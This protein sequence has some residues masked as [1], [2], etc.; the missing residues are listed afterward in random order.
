M[1][2]TIFSTHT[3]LGA[4]YDDEV[5]QP[6]SNYWLN[7]CFPGQITFDTEYVDFSKL[8]DQRK[9]APLVVPTTQGRPMYSAAEQ[10]VQVKPAYVKPKDAVS[11]TRV[12]KKAAGF[13][14]LNYQSN[15]SAA[16]RYNMLVADILNTHRRGIER[17]W[18]WLASE[19]VQHGKVTL[20]GDAYPETVI[21]FER[22]PGH[23]KSLTG[24]ARWG[25]AGVSILGDI[26]DWRKETRMAKY[27]GVT[28]RIT[29]GT[30]AWE[31]MRQDDEIKE[32]LKVDYR[33]NNNGLNLN[34]GVM[35]GLEVEYV[36]RLSGTLDVYVYSDYYEQ[37]DG[38]TVPFMDSRDVVLT[39][40]AVNGVRCFGAIQDKRA[41]WVPLPVFPKMWD[42]EDPSAT[43]IMTQSA[44]LMV[45]I[46]TNA[47]LRARVL[48]D[49]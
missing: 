22:A 11:A 45:P 4:Y 24:G 35:E 19:A 13:A 3:L 6:V 43:Q 20:V 40:P 9:M 49:A 30:D 41:G 32:L 12:I 21:D 14:E 29:V 44:P 17:R 27:G 47:S 16:A 48:N 34:L 15:N 26:E 46:G 18:E 33:P 36:G 1:D 7:L 8:T 31:V 42:E 5:T 39:G 37:E 38:T 28:N 2:N 25:Q 10:R 23:T